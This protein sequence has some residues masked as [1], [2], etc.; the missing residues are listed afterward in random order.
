[1]KSKAEIASGAQERT[2]PESLNQWLSGGG[3][4]Q[5]RCMVPKFFGGLFPTPHT[6]SRLRRG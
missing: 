6:C 3:K 2:A 1:M 4:V 5:I